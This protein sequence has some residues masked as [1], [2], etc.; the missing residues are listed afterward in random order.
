MIN[1]PKPSLLSAKGNVNDKCN[2]ILNY[3]T[4]LVYELEKVIV[5]FNKNNNPKE[6]G[7][8]EISFN[9]NNKS[10]I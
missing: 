8:T 10:I 5:G 1:L 3:L 7:I 9:D 4:K 6:R 2:Y